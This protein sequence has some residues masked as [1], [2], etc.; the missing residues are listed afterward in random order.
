MMISI[1]VNGKDYQ[2]DV[3]PE[4]PLLW[5]LREHLKLNGTKYSCGIGECG[6]CTVHIDG[7]AER[8]CTIPIEEVN[9][10]TIIT[11]EGLSDNHPV[12]RAWIQEQVPQCG[13]CQPGQMMQVASLLADN[14]D[15]D[16]DEIIS[17]MD[18]VLCRCGTYPRIKRAIK[19]AIELRRKEG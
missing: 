14:K 12:K 13:Y 7:L 9:G 15:P 5:V 16:V 17:A 4:V 8:A 18:D 2:I 19:T 6:S 10:S 3:P 11:I 1:N